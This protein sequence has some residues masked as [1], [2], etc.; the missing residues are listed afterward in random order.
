ML[1]TQPYQHL[2][3]MSIQLELLFEEVHVEAMNSIHSL[4]ILLL[5]LLELTKPHL[6]FPILLSLQCQLSFSIFLLSCVVVLCDP[7]DRQ[8]MLQ[9][10]KL[11]E[12]YRNKSY[13][14]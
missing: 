4:G 11:D 13:P 8:T 3:I 5:L 14:E 12:K 10:S 1:P 9:L 7:F 2:S 6:P